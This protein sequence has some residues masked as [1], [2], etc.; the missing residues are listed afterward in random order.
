MSVPGGLT[1]SVG[2]VLGAMVLAS[3]LAGCDAAGGWI[4]SDPRAP[5]AEHFPRAERPV[6]PTVSTGFSTEAARESAGE[7]EKVMGLAGV[8]AGM[9]VADIGAGDGY[10]TIKLAARVGRDGRVLAQDIQPAVI[11]RLADRV[12]RERF[13]NVSLRLGGAD[14]PRL[15][16]NSFDRV[17]LV[18]MYHEIEEPY[19]FLWRLYPAMRKSGQV[20]IVDTDRPTNAHGTPLALLTCEAAAVGFVLVAPADRIDSNVYVARFAATA[21]RPAP[22]AIKL[23]SNAR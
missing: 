3:V 12:M 14:D 4:G 7:A 18:H 1:R 19:A 8:R 17:F 23:C 13:D 20:V 16:D 21:K 11:N 15:P 5:T 2:G 9:T 10:Y 22:D 6:S